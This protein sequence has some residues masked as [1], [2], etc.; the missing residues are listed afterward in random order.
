[1]FISAVWDAIRGTPIASGLDEAAFKRQLLAG[2]TKGLV[3][4]ARADLVG[5]MDPDLVRRS[6]TTDGFGTFHFV[7]REAKEPWER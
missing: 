2:L 1:V 3:S 7:L 4:L 5:A 6:E